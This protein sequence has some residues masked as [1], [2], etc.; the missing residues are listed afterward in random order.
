MRWCVRHPEGERTV[1]IYV[2]FHPDVALSTTGA[3]DDQASRRCHPRHAG[4]HPRSGGG[5]T[6]GECGVAGA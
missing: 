1:G 2:L 6:A 5:A 4:E 3:E